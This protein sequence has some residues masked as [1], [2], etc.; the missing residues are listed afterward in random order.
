LQLLL[1]KIIS[2]KTVLFIT[3]A[4]MPQILNLS[5]TFVSVEWEYGICLSPS[6]GAEEDTWSF[7]GRSA[8]GSER[9][10]VQKRQLCGLY[11][12]LNV[13]PMKNT[14]KEQ[15]DL[16]YN[17]TDSDSVIKTS[18]LTFWHRSFTFKI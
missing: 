4:V 8:S 11:C 3:T 18:Q 15:T 5:F 6:E 10:K 13:V 2:Q 9:R 17:Y 16:N 7:E 14:L 12:S 1:K